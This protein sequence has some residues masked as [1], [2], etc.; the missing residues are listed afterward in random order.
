MKEEE[1]RVHG[2]SAGSGGWGWS[3]VGI[4]LANMHKALGLCM[5][6]HITWA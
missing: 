1:G 4:M 2:Y 6:H 5:K 3:S